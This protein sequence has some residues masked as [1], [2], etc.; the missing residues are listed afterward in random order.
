MKKKT[1]KKLI[2]GGAICALSLVST[3]ASSWPC[4]GGRI[5]MP[6]FQAIGS[7]GAPPML[8]CPSSLAQTICCW[9][10]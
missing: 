8:V 1:F 3:P 7:P 4:T 6:A 2:A 5:L 9:G 10:K